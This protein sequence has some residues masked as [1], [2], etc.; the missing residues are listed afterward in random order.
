MI[1]WG[2]ADTASVTEAE[3]LES[4][5]NTT[6]RK[7]KLQSLSGQHIT[8]ADARD[9]EKLNTIIRRDEGY[10]IFSNIRGSPAAWKQM[11]LDC[12]AKIKQIGTCSFFITLSVADTFWTEKTDPLTHNDH[13]PREY[14][15]LTLL[16]KW[17]M[18]SITLLGQLTKHMHFVSHSL[19]WIAFTTTGGGRSSFFSIHLLSS[20]P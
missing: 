12:L 8:A 1:E 3:Q 10:R 4:E 20:S 5:I 11:Q 15:V 14:H 18:A 13:L 7:S 9:P 2:R 19:F 6:V 16:I 17:F